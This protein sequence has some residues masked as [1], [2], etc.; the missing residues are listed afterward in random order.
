LKQY[1][2]GTWFGA[3]KNTISESS[4]VITVF[5][6]VMLIPTFYVT[7]VSPWCLE[8]GIIFPFWVLIVIIVVTGLIVLLL[9]YKLFTPSSFTF[10]ADQFWQH[11]DNPISKKLEEQDKRLREIES[12]LDR[13][14]SK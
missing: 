14:G 2:I 10:W 11:G 1:N 12:K 5:N 9:Q 13:M 8:K 4:F 6:M 7:V 3:V